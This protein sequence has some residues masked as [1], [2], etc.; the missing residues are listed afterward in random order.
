MGG[1]AGGKSSPPEK[2]K[3]KEVG[4]IYRIFAE[5]GLCA[6]VRGKRGEKTEWIAARR[7]TDAWSNAINAAILRGPYFN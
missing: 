4:G 2:E 5:C 1:G 6:R 7:V 3:E